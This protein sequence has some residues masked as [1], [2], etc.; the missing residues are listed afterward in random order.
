MKLVVSPQAR[1]YIKSEAAYLKKRSPQAAL[2]FRDDLGRLRKNLLQ[3]PHLG[4]ETSEIPI[5][6][7]RRF[8]MG[9]YLVDYEISRDDIVILKIR[10][11]HQSP[12][13]IV[14]EDDFDYEG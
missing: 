1:D 12:P 2:N 4:H 8:V 7:I 11:G 3:F 5:A 9:A 6:G 14:V 10:H 13:S